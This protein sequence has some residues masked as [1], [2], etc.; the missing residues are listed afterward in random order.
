MKGGIDILARV[1]AG[2]G[3]KKSHGYYLLI[4]GVYTAVSWVIAALIYPPPFNFIDVWISS[5]GDPSV[6]NYAGYVHFNISLVIFGFGLVPHYLYVRNHLPPEA[7]G[8]GIA[9][10]IIC[11][12]ASVAWGLIGFFPNPIQPTHDT[13]A[14][15][16]FFS[17]PAGLYFFYGTLVFQRVKLKKPWPNLAITWLIFA[18]MIVY[19]SLFAGYVAPFLPFHDWAPYEWGAFASICLG[20][21][22][23]YFLI[24]GDGKAKV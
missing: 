14:Y 9:G 22:S 7:K 10:A 15:L 5:L 2:K 18:E 23:L 6:L 20:I 11:S 16:S 3:D 1:V 4:I 24:P 19:L 17:F 21:F 12:I 8:A 13:V